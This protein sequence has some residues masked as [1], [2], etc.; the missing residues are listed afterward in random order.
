MSNVDRIRSAPIHLA[1]R[2][3]ACEPA[4]QEHPL[5]LLFIQNLVDY[6]LEQD[7]RAKSQ[8]EMLCSLIR[9]LNTLESKP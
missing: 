3:L 5:L 8:N 4:A 7:A 6:I 9:R 1:L 2:A